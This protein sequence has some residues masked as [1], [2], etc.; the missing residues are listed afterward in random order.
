MVLVIENLP[1]KAF[2]F[3]FNSYH[4]KILTP[5]NGQLYKGQFFEFQWR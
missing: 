3:F 2:P 4:F 1:L 5:K